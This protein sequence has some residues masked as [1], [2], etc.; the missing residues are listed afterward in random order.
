MEFWIYIL[1]NI[2]SPIAQVVIGIAALFALRQI[3]ISKKS[4]S[5]QSRRESIKFATDLVKTYLSDIIALY[6]KTDEIKEK[7]KF[8]DFEGEINLQHFIIAE[9]NQSSEILKKHYHDALLMLDK[10]KSFA[11]AELDVANAIEAFST[12]FIA[13]VADEKIA[14]DTIGKTFCDNIKNNYFLYCLARR[15]PDLERHYYQNTIALYNV[16]APRIKKRQLE[17]LKEEVGIE[18][19]SINSKDIKIIGA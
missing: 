16:W 7:L 8:L 2:I 17:A 13:G 14:F 1:P 4:I 19:G 12:P 11:V 6:N 9:V 5:V 3:S 15:R 10:E 18:I